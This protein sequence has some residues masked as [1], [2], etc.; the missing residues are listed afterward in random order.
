MINQASV[1]SDESLAANH[2]QHHRYD[3]ERFVREGFLETANMVR[4]GRIVSFDVADAIAELNAG[5]VQRN[6]AFVATAR[7]IRGMEIPRR[8]QDQL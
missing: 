6:G 3:L 8:F 7:V 5:I 4:Q 2:G 1:W